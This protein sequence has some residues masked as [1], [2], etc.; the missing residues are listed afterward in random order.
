MARTV[1]CMRLASAI[2]AA[3]PCVLSVKKALPP[4]IPR[5]VSAVFW[6]ISSPEA[7]SSAP[8]ASVSEP[9]PKPS[10]PLPLCPVLWGDWPRSQIRRRWLKVVRSETVSVTMGAKPTQERCVTL[11][12]QVLT[13]SQRAH[14]RLSWEERFARNA[15]LA[16][17]SPLVVTIHGLPATFAS[18]FGFGLL[19]AG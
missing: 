19:P 16:T 12:E 17:S 5:R 14:W 8:E 9:P 13:R 1:C 2:A 3:V 6:P 15:R 18:S 11:R 7:V 4:G 10:E